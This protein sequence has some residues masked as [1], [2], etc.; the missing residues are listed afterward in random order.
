MENSKLTEESILK[1]IKQLE[2]PTFNEE[3]LPFVDIIEEI[4]ENNIDVADKEEEV[5]PDSTF[6]K[7]IPIIGNVVEKNA[8]TDHDILNYLKQLELEEEL[9]VDEYPEWMENEIFGDDDTEMETED[10]NPVNQS[11]VRTK[12]ISE[13]DNLGKKVRFAE[14]DQVLEYDVEEEFIDKP[15]RKELG[16]SKF[17]A[18]RMGILDEEE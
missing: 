18:R 14:T 1:L 13:E 9:S 7:P 11:P 17:K 12:A 15:T 3:G 2:K 5:E 4:N 8:V 6:T 16:I 10:D